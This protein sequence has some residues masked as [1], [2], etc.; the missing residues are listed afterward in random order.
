MRAARAP[1]AGAAHQTAVVRDEGVGL[2]IVI[3]GQQEVKFGKNEKG[4]TA[5][6]VPKSSLTSVLTKPVAA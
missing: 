2:V 1:C 4:N 5:L 6:R 3:A